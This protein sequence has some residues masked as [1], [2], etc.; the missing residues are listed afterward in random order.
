M[1]DQGSDLRVFLSRKDL[2]SLGIS[3]SNTTLLRWEAAKKFPRRVRF[4][5][6]SVAWIQSEIVAWCHARGDERANHI[7]ADV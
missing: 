3:K 6:T 2:A 1:S 5:R 7:Y 4:A